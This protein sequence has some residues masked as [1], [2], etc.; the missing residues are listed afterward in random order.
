MN[1]MLRFISSLW[2]LCVSFSFV[3]AQLTLL[4]ELQWP[5]SINENHGLVDMIDSEDKILLVL[6]YTYTPAIEFVQI[7]KSSFSV[8][9]TSEALIIDNS[10]IDSGRYEGTEDCQDYWCVLIRNGSDLNNGTMLFRFTKS[11]L[12]E[13]E[14]SLLNSGYIKAQSKNGNQRFNAYKDD[15]L[16]TIEEYQI[17]DSFISQNNYILPSQPLASITFL[18]DFVHLS[19]YQ[20]AYRHS[21]SGYFSGNL[22]SLRKATLEGDTILYTAE[23]V[24]ES[25][26][27]L[28]DTNTSFEAEE[29]IHRIS[30]TTFMYVSLFA[31]SYISL[32][33][34][35]TAF[36]LFDYDSFEPIYQVQHPEPG[37]EEEFHLFPEENLALVKGFLNV[38]ATISLED[39]SLLSEFSLPNNNIQPL[40]WLSSTRLYSQ[41]RDY[42]NH[43][44]DLYYTD[45]QTEETQTLS[46]DDRLLS[47][48][49]LIVDANKVYAY[50]TDNINR[51][52][53]LMLI[54]NGLI[55]G[56]DEVDLTSS[57]SIY[58][59]PS[60]GT[61][62]I[63]DIEFY[64]SVKLYNMKGQSLSYQLEDNI[65]TLD[66]PQNG[67]F[68][69]VIIQGDRRI[70][71]KIIINL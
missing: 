57:L 28:H 22:Q 52:N 31:S 18:A 16:Y 29:R 41:E 50:A 62:L 63:S 2:I 33:N 27:P 23:Y 37:Y 35:E 9:W 56:S 49:K 55:S 13:P 26:N 46:F 4:D 47:N 25:L 24:V 66:N 51:I 42:P 15:T 3:M 70:T 45:F 59:N 67:I 7:D 38:F 53:H 6:N 11:V 68:L 14:I 30:D 61:F 71:E 44:S 8:D 39:G 1:T 19:D 48:E 21:Y 34:L 60:N 32:T 5:Q 36:V 12:I 65:I 43:S 58:P 54:E 69:L 17:S 20:I 10:F 40:N 64:D